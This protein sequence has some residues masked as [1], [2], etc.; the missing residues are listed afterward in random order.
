[1]KTLSILG[2]TGSIGTQ[3]L[4]CVARYPESLGISALACGG[5]VEIFSEQVRKFKPQIAS[6]RGPEEAK[7]LKN[8]LRDLKKPPE[9]V[10]GPDG[11]VKVA[12]WPGVTSVL[13]ALVGAVGLP[14]TLAALRANM[15]LLLAN[16]ESLVMAG[17]IIQ[18]LLKDGHGSL[19]PVD[20]EHSAIFQCIGGDLSRLKE[21][22]RLILTASGGP[23]REMEINE[24]DSITVKQALLH[25]TW[26]MGPKITIDSATL[27][28]K[29]L[30]II[31]AHYLFGIAPEKIDVLIHPA[32]IVHS[33]V[34]FHDGSML[35]QLSY[36]TMQIPIQ[37]ALLGGERKPTNVAPLDLVREGKLEFFEPD[38]EKFPAL[39]LARRALTLGGTAACVLNA[40]NEEAVRLFL[41]GK[42][43]FPSITSLIESALDH[44]D[45]MET[46]ETAIINA[47]LWAR[48]H[49]FKNVSEIRQFN[50]DIK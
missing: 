47:D 41:E 28:N 21:V 35:A 9:I 23:F 18:K 6:V 5:Q 3:A 12:T 50:P 48:N 10:E 17:S 2:S 36:P 13:N 37:Y 24:F 40:A 45:V 33:L 39:N 26:K 34:E 38:S 11:L 31:E 1:M 29:G 27:V 46:T 32:S 22:S 14:P 16:K 44:H 25:P 20:S 7:R 8:L 49:V 15:E 19:V 43:N 42:I 30:E 4:E